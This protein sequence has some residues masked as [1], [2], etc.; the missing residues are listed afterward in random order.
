[1]SYNDHFQIKFQFYDDDPIPTDGYSIDEVRLR[2]NA[3][4]VLSW[5]GDE[6][7]LSDGLHPE[8]G[9]VRDDYNY[10]VRYQ[11]PDGN[12]PDYVWV[13]IRKSGNPITGNPFYLACESGDYDQGVI[14]SYTQDGLEEGFDYSYRFL[15][16]DAFGIP[17]T[18]TPL[19][20]AP[21]VTRYFWAYLPFTLMDAGPPT[22]AP[23]LADISNPGG[24]F[25]YT[26]N[27]SQ[28]ERASRYV[29]EQDVEGGFSNP[30]IVYNGVLT[31]TEVSVAEIGAYYYRV[32]GANLSG[33]GPWSQVK[34][35]EVTIVP[36]PCPQPGTWR[37]TTDQGR[38]ISF[39]LADTPTCQ[40]DSL[41]ISAHLEYCPLSNNTMDITAT[42]QDIE[43]LARE[44][45]IHK[46]YYTG[47]C[48][49]TCS[50]NVTGKFSS[51]TAASG[52][53]SYFLCNES[54]PLPGRFCYGS[55]SWTASY[56]P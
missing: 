34:S 33:S 31:T 22:S 10:R 19:I 29:L 56:V 39:S 25:E 3:P 54:V 42:Y 4:P 24:Y 20:D 51:Q 53:Y 26:L 30:T 41:T 46:E 5:P 6:D 12:P 36:P 52:R 45:E 32:K 9:D 50:E 17:A 38:P 47:P 44:F 2:P 37:G 18:P 21:D 55:G 15:A 1:M 7:Y 27:W 48:D 35:V 11:D 8:S 49:M 40:I 23:I 14:C 43:V 16:Q 28:V 13:D